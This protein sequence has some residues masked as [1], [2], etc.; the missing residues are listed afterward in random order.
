M[1]TLSLHLFWWLCSL[2]DYE[3]AP[4]NQAPWSVKPAAGVGAE[5]GVVPLLPIPGDGAIDVDI[6]PTL[7]WTRHP[8]AVSYKVYAGGWDDPDFRENTTERSFSLPRLESGAHFYWRVEAVL[9]D[10][11]TRGA[12]SEGLMPWSKRP[13][14]RLR[15][16]LPSASSLMGYRRDRL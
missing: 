10:S 13:K 2:Y 6:Q 15:A 11:S 9:A 7:R 3:V 12:T 1:S 14:A 4:A 5:Y 8:E 16:D